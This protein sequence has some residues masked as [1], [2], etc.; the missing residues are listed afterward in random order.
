MTTP[1]VL[2]TG[3]GPFLDVSENPSEQIARVLE[4]ESPAGV[5]VRALELPVSFQRSREVLDKFLDGLGERP[6]LLLGLGLHRGK[7]FRVERRAR[8]VMDSAKPDNDGVLAAAVAPLGE[9]DLAT[10]LDLDRLEACLTSPGLEP[11]SQS[12]EAGGYVCERT[13]HALLSAGER[14]DVPAL[15]IHIPKAEYLSTEE[16]A[17]HLRAAIEVL[18][19]DVG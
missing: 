18:L 14:L 3:F 1:L 8:R 5:R 7:F 10:R 15:F 9:R 13:Y 4:L 12:D 17:E 11:V 6:A 16:Q 2:V 19:S